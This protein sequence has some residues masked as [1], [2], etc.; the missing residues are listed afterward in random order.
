MFYPCPLCGSDIILWLWSRTSWSDGEEPSHKPW[1]IWLKWG[2][3]CGLVTSQ[4]TTSDSSVVYLKLRLVLIR[5][6]PRFK[7]QFGVE[8]W[9][10]FCWQPCAGCLWRRLLL[11]CKPDNK[12]QLTPF[13]YRTCLGFTSRL[14]RTGAVSRC[15]S[16]DATCNRWDN[17]NFRNETS[18]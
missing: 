1:L 12:H 7:T 2:G 9:F 8:T 11:D 17:S 14:K 18:S 16:L 3:A 5:L 15:R 13:I 10:W 4:Q 6:K